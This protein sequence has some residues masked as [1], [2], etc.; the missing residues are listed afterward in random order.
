MR[1]H[2]GRTTKGMRGKNDIL[3]VFDHTGFG[4]STS[5]PACPIE[6]ARVYG[7]QFYLR[8]AFDIFSKCFIRG[9]DLVMTERELL[10]PERHCSPW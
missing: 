1:T 3:A 4:G 7:L 9:I 5:N 10:P 6:G 2:S 8:I